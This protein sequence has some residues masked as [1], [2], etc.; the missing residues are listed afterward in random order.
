VPV[1][2]LLTGFG[3]FPGAPL[4]PTGA[5][6]LQIAKQ[7]ISDVQ[8]ATH[9]FETSYAAV[10]RELPILIARQKPDIVLMFGLASRA[11]RVRIETRARNARAAYPD[12][13]GLIPRGAI[14]RGA[15][16]RMMRLPLQA[17]LVAA[18]ATRVPTVLSRDAGRYLCNYLCWRATEA[19]DKSAGP[20]FVAFIHVPRLPSK[21][22]RRQSA[23]RSLTV[24]DIAALGTAVLRVLVASARSK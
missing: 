1:R 9:V 24:P 22:F 7:K 18:R 3:P 21:T 13:T 16:A 5:I 15:S 20:K 23:A 12:A 2:V 19:A 4:N 10:D 17:M 8:I 6:I 11:T 14:V